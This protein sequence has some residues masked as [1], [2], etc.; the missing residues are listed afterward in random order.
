MS[1]RTLSLQLLRLLLDTSVISP[2]ATHDQLQS[3]AKFI[4]G[5]AGFTPHVRSVSVNVDQAVASDDGVQELHTLSLT[6]IDTPCLD[7]ADEAAAQRVLNDILRHLDARFS[8][9]VEDVSAPSLPV[10]ARL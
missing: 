4:Q 5:C 6:L 10:H 3:V 9:S 2:S 8:E 1:P 7:F